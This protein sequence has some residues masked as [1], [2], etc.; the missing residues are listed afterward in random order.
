MDALEPIRNLKDAI[1]GRIGAAICDLASGVRI[2][3]G[4]YTGKAGN[5]YEPTQSASRVASV[6]RI[7]E[8]LDGA[9]RTTGYKDTSLTE[10]VQRLHEGYEAKEPLYSFG[11]LSD[12]HLQY[13]TGRDDFRR[14]LEYLQERVPFTCICGDLVAYATE[15]NAQEYARYVADYAG[16]MPVYEC[17]GNHETYNYIDQTV[18]G[19]TLTGEMLDRWTAATGKETCYTVPYGDDVFVFLSL[20]S[21]VADDLFVDGGLEWLEQTLEANRGR[22]CFVWQHVQNPEDDS[23]DPSH[24]YSN[25][26]SGASGAEFLRIIRAHREHVVWF[27]GHTHLT[28]NEPIAPISE[29]H[30]YKSVHI[31]SLASPRFY[32]A[33]SNSVV[34]WYYDAYG[35]RIYGATKAEGYIADV[36]EDHIVLR[37]INFAAGDNKDEI[38]PMDDEI[39]ALYTAG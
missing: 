13:E 2:L 14:A 9:N 30:G 19:K 11:V 32:D 15:E 25:I 36:Y 20:K 1:E 21:E 34:D 23:A 24:R 12:V 10:A 8:I 18:V 28:L 38:A 16:G 37:G 31:P 3:R 6:R 26:L 5:A 35:N 4:G 29:S 33:E 39:Y 17:A 7:A 22:R 27:H